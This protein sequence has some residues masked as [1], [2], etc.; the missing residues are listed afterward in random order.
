MME[1]HQYL[2]DLLDELETVESNSDEHK[3]LS[4]RIS[5]YYTTQ[6]VVGTHPI[7]NK[8]LL[9]TFWMGLRKDGVLTS[10]WAMRKVPKLVAQEIKT[11]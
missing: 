11:W 1:Y 4:V 5:Q 8:L 9:R 2:I 3:K 10:L 6:S 7:P